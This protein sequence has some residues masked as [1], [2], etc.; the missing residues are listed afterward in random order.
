MISGD[1]HLTNFS[2]RKTARHRVHRDTTSRTRGTLRRQE[3]WQRRAAAH[4]VQRQMASRRPP[5]AGGA[6]VLEGE[7]RPVG[8]GLGDE[9][10]RLHALAELPR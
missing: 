10:A 1:R 8:R 9:T 5:R 4:L 3:R 2:A 6:A 7:R